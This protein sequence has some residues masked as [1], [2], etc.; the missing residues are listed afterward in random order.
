MLLIIPCVGKKLPDDL[1]IISAMSYDIEIVHDILQFKFGIVLVHEARETGY[2]IIV[3]VGNEPCIDVDL[4]PFGNI[5]DPPQE[6]VDPLAIP[7]GRLYIAA[8][9]YHKEAVICHL[10]DHK[11]AG[12]I[13]FI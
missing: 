9:V 6:G 13:L 11:G 10:N 4:L 8:T 2:M 1:H 7:I 5:G 12:I 3:I